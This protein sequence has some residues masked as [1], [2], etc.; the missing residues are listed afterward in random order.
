MS[1]LFLVTDFSIS[2]VASLA[3]L[4][5][6]SSSFCSSIDKMSSCLVMAASSLDTLLSTVSLSD[7]NSCRISCRSV[8]FSVCSFSSLAGGC[9]FAVLSPS[10]GLSVLD[11]LLFDCGVSLFIALKISDIFGV[12][13][14]LDMMRYIYCWGVID[15]MYLLYCMLS[16]NSEC[17]F[18]FVE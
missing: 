11:V 16:M 15:N 7:L 12:Y 10:A 4:D 14:S 17:I 18:P 2:V 9:F 5:S 3:F 1:R 6:V 8:L 13:F